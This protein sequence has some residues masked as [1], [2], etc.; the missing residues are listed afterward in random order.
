MNHIN[1]VLVARAE[2]A[3]LPSTPVF[4][5]EWKRDI[6]AEMMNEFQFLYGHGFKLSRLCF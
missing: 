3:S 5:V 6:E 2:S 4:D 1:G